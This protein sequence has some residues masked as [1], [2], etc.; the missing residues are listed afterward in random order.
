MFQKLLTRSD[1]P[2]IFLSDAERLLV[3]ISN[4]FPELVKLST[5]GQTWES[6]DIQLLTI[7]SQGSA[8]TNSTQGDSSSD[9]PASSEQEISTDP[10]KGE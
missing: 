5:I 6:R 8:Q 4:E 1:V 3:S 7:N 9:K 10:K 2:H